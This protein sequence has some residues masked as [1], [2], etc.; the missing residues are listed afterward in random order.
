[1]ITMTKEQF[2]KTVKERR[3]QAAPMDLAR[4]SE[5][6]FRKIREMNA[7]L[8]ASSIYCYVDFNN[9]VQTR[10]FLAQAIAE[11]KQVAVPRIEKD[12]MHFYYIDSLRQIVTN[13]NGLPEPK[14]N[15]ERANSANALVIVPGLAFDPSCARIGYGKGYYDRFLREERTHMTVAVAYDF[16]VFE[17]V[18]QEEGDVRLQWLITESRRF[19]RDVNL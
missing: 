2:R 3:G 10:S 13:K 17:E 16:Q 7:Y 9:E 11:G 12:A 4:D 5:I 1:M 19:R 15:T 14:Q 8:I 18:P 6:I